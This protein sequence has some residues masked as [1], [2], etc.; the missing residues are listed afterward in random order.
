MFKILP[1]HLFIGIVVFFPLCGLRAR[2]VHA[3]IP[4]FERAALIALYNGTDGDNWN[5]NSGWKTPPLDVDGFALPGTEN[6]WFGV[7]TDAGNTNVTQINLGNNQLTGSIPPEIGDLSNLQSLSLHRNQLSGD[8]QSE[9]GNLANLQ[10]IILE[11][12]QLTGTIPTELGNLA[13][14]INLD[15]QGNQLTGNI[16][17]ELGNLINLEALD[18]RQ[19]QLSGDIP[20]EIGNL[21]NLEGLVLT[22]NQLTGDIPVEIGDLLNL[23]VLRLDNNELTGNIPSELGNLT[24]LQMLELHNN[25]L[26]GSIPGE[27]DNLINLATLLI[28]ANMLRGAIPM[29]LINLSGLANTD[30]GYNALYIDNGTLGTFLNNVDP[31]W[32]DTQTVAPENVSARTTSDTSAEVSWTPIL[33][34]TDSGEYQVSYSTSSGGPYILFDTTADK[35]ASQMEV[36]GLDPGTT[37][38]FVV[39]TRTDPHVQNQNTVDSENSQEATAKTTGDSGKSNG[40]FITTAAYGSLMAEEIKVLSI[41]RIIFSKTSAVRN[42]LFDV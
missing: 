1:K 13:N 12:N 23:L 16:P 30:I 25:R 31:D 33:Y 38:F 35:S 9:L 8:I 17:A 27:L 11:F 18:L 5:N 14:L 39:N 22:F 42:S 4:A 29:T 28:N 20:I 3:A 2:H 37:Y 34:T 7:T 41:I 24:N 10:A 36:T 26:S 6:T 40:C 15:L 19:N 32:E 21:A